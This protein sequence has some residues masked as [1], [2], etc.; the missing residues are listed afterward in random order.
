MAE[1]P[2]VKNSKVWGSEGDGIES[3]DKMSAG[4]ENILREEM[5]PSDLMASNPSHSNKNSILVQQEV[6]KVV[7]T[8]N[9]EHLYQPNFNDDSYEVAQEET[10]S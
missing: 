9:I 10:F 4:D 3:A 7:L 5:Q 6:D 8:D 1:S 2:T